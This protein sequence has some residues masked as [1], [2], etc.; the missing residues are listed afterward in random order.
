[1]KGKYFFVLSIF[2]LGQPLWAQDVE[3][4]IQTH[5][6]E[7]TARSP[8]AIQDF[9][10]WEVTDIVP[11]LNPE[12]QH[13]YVQQYYQGIPIENGRYKLTVKEGMVSWEINQFI[14][15]LSS[16]AAPATAA[17]SPEVAVLK[18]ASEKQLGVPELI[19][20]TRVKDVF[21][22][23]DSGISKEPIEVKKVYL[24]KDGVLYLSWSVK[25]YQLDG[26]HLWNVHVD[27]HT[28]T[29]LQTADRILKCNFGILNEKVHKP[30]PTV[31]LELK[32]HEEA[33][34][35]TPT[36]ADG[37]SYNVYALGVESPNHGDRS[38]VVNPADDTASPYGWHDTNGSAGAEHTI[39]AGNNVYAH[40][41]SDGNNGIGMSPDGGADLDFDF[42]IDFSL[43]PDNNLDAAT[44][45]LFYWINIVHDVWYHYGFDEASGNFQ[46]NNY[47]N[48]GL[49]S[50]FIFAEAQDGDVTN[51]AK[52][53]L[54]IDGSN[55]KIEMGLWDGNPQIDSDFDNLVIAHE[56]GHGI[57]SRLVGGPS[58]IGLNNTE[59]MGEGWSDWIGLMMTMEPGDTGA[60]PRTIGTY[61]EGQGI[62]GSG[63]R[64]TPYSTDTMINDADYADIDNL[65][66]PHGV[67]YV[68]GTI[69]WDITWAL[70]DQEGYDPD[71]Y[72]GTGGNNIAMALVIEGLK[73]TPLE[74]G[75]V[76]GRDAILQAD[77]DLYN[78]Q[79]NCLIWEAFASRGVGAGA[80]ENN[81]GGE[82]TNTDQ[83]TSYVGTCISCFSDS[84]Y[85]MP[86]GSSPNFEYINRVQL[87]SIDNLT[88]GS[89]Y[90]DYTNLITT[91]EQT[92]TIT[93][94]PE[95][96]GSIYEQSYA[97]WIDFNGDGDFMDDAEQV[98]DDRTSATQI[99]GSFEL[100]DTYV[101]CTTRMRVLMTLHSTYGT[102]NA[103][104]YGETEDYTVY[105]PE[106]CTPSGANPDEGYIGLISSGL[107][108]AGGIYNSSGVSEG[109]YADYTDISRTIYL[110]NRVRIK[111]QWGPSVT[112]QSCAVWIDYNQDSDFYDEDEL[113]FNQQL[114]AVSSEDI[115][116]DFEV[117]GHALPGSTRMR[118]ALLGNASS[119]L[120]DSCG[121]F[122][123]GEVE[124]YTVIYDPPGGYCYSI[125]KNDLGFIDRIQLGSID[126]QSGISSGYEDYTNHS[127]T[128]GAV[129][130]M[131]ITPFPSPWGDPSSYY[132]LGYAVWIDYNQDGDFFDSQELVF[133]KEPTY[134][135]QVIG[136]FS[137]PQD[138]R[139]GAT[140]MRIASRINGVPEEP[141]GQSDSGEVEDYT[142]VIDSSTAAL[143]A[144]CPSNGN[145]QNY[146]YIKR[147]QLGAID[148]QTGASEGGYGDYTDL[149]TNL[150]ITNT[151][152]ITP[153]FLK[154]VYLEGY[155][156]WVDFNA[157]GDFEDD[158]EL[159][160]S[161]TP[162][163]LSPVSGSFGV[164]AGAVIG[165]TIMRVAMEYN[166]IPET[167]DSFY[168]GEVEDYTVTV[169][170]SSFGIAPT[171]PPETTIANNNSD[172]TSDFM[173]YP[174]PVKG[175]LSIQI[176][177]A[178]AQSYVI[179][180]MQGQIVASRVYRDVIDVSHLPS[181]VYI[182]EIGVD[183]KSQNKRFIKE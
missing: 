171:T 162:T 172:T 159:V 146:E 34:C 135:L 112:T 50:D 86:S 22:Y 30:I 133:S 85:C 129:N 120:P 150:G 139:D 5:F 55:P 71:L 18:V 64:P 70:I 59:Q 110:H 40:E 168:Y 87:G 48:G 43:S 104:V 103:L 9:S 29:I 3:G 132:N 36:L 1:M 26:E 175:R 109:G 149:S 98:L 91:L 38:I 114:I 155:A 179:Y 84:D 160:F 49:G 169:V 137:L 161:Q 6:S 42:P 31:D 97:V 41:D 140:R 138:I 105:L 123:I 121:D 163:T 4:I 32:A 63:I 39:T 72:N 180:N 60:T 113:I 117:P 147:V 93:I 58:A 170:Q 127:T 73:N 56:Y 2:M 125:G 23:A 178:S 183:G 134:D 21:E 24:H 17:L 106:Y 76:S 111:P 143:I 119:N 108:S 101:S 13:V 152:T 7:N 166:S 96:N 16:K 88:E 100:P 14:S 130:T 45:N 94:T 37:A 136:T 92:N 151:I 20:T 116:V 78:G 65:L 19:V 54:T 77:Q 165:E 167:C 128:L 173:I 142:V 61:V 75:F 68:F 182:I 95:F 89:G 154:G 25:L 102:C 10:E 80:I 131:T 69:L 57:S 145:Y 11:S 28:G 83:T 33:A 141:C 82:N 44:T 115:V 35:G 67:G 90:G 118:I 124:D 99:T 52:Y 174:N 181:G 153:E 46:E 164:P 177:N 81:D 15:D 27:A 144:Y 158:G 176:A 53:I 148:N 12:I 126:N 47:G 62:D 122:E 66:T 8:S 51:N 157:D 156:A 107:I 74:P 79:Y